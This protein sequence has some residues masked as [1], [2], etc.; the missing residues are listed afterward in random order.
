MGRKANSATTKIRVGK[1]HNLK[2]GD[3]KKGSPVDVAFENIKEM[4]INQSLGAWPQL[5]YWPAVAG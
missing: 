5:G 1:Y 3:K 2:R 4:M